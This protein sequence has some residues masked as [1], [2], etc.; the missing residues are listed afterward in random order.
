MGNGSIRD[1]L[2]L[3]EVERARVGGLVGRLKSVSEFLSGLFDA[4][5]DEDAP[6]WMASVVPWL[7]AA[8]EAAVESLPVVKF[9]AQLFGGLVEDKDTDALAL[10]ACTLAYEQALYDALV[11]VEAPSVDQLRA[12]VKAGIDAMPAAEHDFRTFSLDAALEHPFVR[13]ADGFVA[14]FARGA[15]YDDTL[16]RRLTVEVHQRFTGTLKR[17]LTEKGAVERFR[18]LLDRLRLG[19]AEAQAFAWLAAHADY[20]RR[21]FERFPVLGREPFALEDVYVDTDCGVLTWEQ[22]GGARRRPHTEAVRAPDPQDERFGGRQPLLETVLD[23]FADPAF[24]DAVV[25]QGPAGSGKSAFTLR[26]AAELTRR[27]LFPIRIRLRDVRLDVPVL[28]ALKQAVTVYDPHTE[29]PPGLSRPDDPFAGDRIFSERVELGRARIC[30]YVVILDGWDEIS[31]SATEGFRKRLAR[32]LESVRN[33]F[34]G[35]ARGV[36]VRVVVTGRPSPDFE[37]SAFLRDHTPVLTMRHLKPDALQTYLRRLVVAMETRPLE[38]GEAADGGDVSLRRYEPALTKYREGF[39]RA[40]AEERPTRTEPDGQV[41]DVLGLPLLAHIAVRVMREWQ[42]DVAELVAS[43]TIL[44][45]RLIDVTAR[46]GGKGTADGLDAEAIVHVRQGLR[47]LLQDTA[48]AMTAWGGEALPYAEWAARMRALRPNYTE[49]F[50]RVTNDSPLHALVVSFYFK[51]GGK[52]QGCEFLHKSFREYLFAE[53]VIEALKTAATFGPL[54]ERTTYWKDFAADDP[55]SRFVERLGMLLGVQ[56]LSPDVCRHLAELVRWEVERERAEAGETRT[57]SLAQWERVRDAL[58]DLWDWW[59]EAVHLRWQP[60]RDLEALKQGPPRVRR[61]LTWGE[62]LRDDPEA[63]V[64]APVRT[65]MID[66]ELGDALFRL[67]ALL[68]FHIAV[69]R[70]WL[71]GARDESGRVDPTR[72]WSTEP[73]PGVGC[74][75][76]QVV[77]GDYVLFAPAGR[78]NTFF[79]NYVARIN[80]AGWQPQG[81]FPG[82]VRL[83]GTFLEGVEFQVPGPRHPASWDYACLRG[84][85][86]SCSHLERDSLQYVDGRGAR[87]TASLAGSANLTGSHLGRAMLAG[88]AFERSTLR[89]VVLRDAYLFNACLV[90]AELDGSDFSGAEVARACLEP[91]TAAAADFS[92]TRLD[93]HQYEALRRARANLDNASVFG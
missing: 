92:G 32:M 63:G 1:A 90:S 79:S 40:H 55:R 71:D 66:A 60:E 42:G 80:A 28:D 16:L 67:N 41:L 26:L 54:P 38:A 17:I 81:P 68:H 31:I 11:A 44:Y 4:W 86:M 89:H 29:E 23:Y 13:E 6:K 37:D 48:A 45:R 62:P 74:R 50:R 39:E 49:L 8:G 58:A 64:P 33:H 53:A 35:P 36:P 70:G 57:L 20:Q 51:T 22:I 72:L 46:H 78:P 59:A 14:A 83:D 30:P 52:E 7:G 34:L 43:P 65:T 84:T 27:G 69:R 76:Y 61:I 25:I 85:Q 18:P 47:E 73:T 87:F 10:V 12:D 91:S 88:V 75:R 77:V 21:Q 82:G 9:A 56:W 93:P 5:K 3:T 19:S 24:R 2:A 15:G